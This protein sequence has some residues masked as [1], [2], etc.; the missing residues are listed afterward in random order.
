MSMI[1]GHFVSRAA[2]KQLDAWIMSLKP[3]ALYQQTCH[4]EEKT[5]L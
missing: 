2:I 3:I 4:Q 5:M 1:G